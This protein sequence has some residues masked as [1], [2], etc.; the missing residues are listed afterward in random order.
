M[1]TALRVWLFCVTTALVVGGWLSYLHFLPRG[2][3]AQ[4]QTAPTQGQ[5]IN[6]E[7]LANGIAV[8]RGHLSDDQDE[9]LRF[10]NANAMRITAGRCANE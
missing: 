5:T 3:K 9:I 4:A 1:K 2:A 8:R 10:M 6:P 7:R